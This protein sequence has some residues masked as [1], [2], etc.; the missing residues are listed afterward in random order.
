[1]NRQT[2]AIIF[3]LLPLCVSAA[4]NKGVFNGYT[5]GMTKEQAKT[6]GVENCH[7]GDRETSRNSENSDYVYCSPPGNKY[8]LGPIRP[9]KA[10]LE[11][12]RKTGILMLI[13][14]RF[15]LDR[16]MATLYE[17]DRQFGLHGEQDTIHPLSAT[18]YGWK[19]ADDVEITGYLAKRWATDFQI[20]FKYIRGRAKAIRNAEK[21]K[22]RHEENLRREVEGFE[23]K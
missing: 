12:D 4:P 2:L 18:Y 1:M 16:H 10:I 9:E 21:G 22:A 11:F 5:P 3:V 13:D 6:I 7:I 17:M 19:T 8:L 14:L 20:T 15:P 23:S